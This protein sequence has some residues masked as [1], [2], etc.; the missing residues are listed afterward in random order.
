[1][2]HLAINTLGLKIDELLTRHLQLIAENRSL[3]DE[4]EKLRS[5]KALLSSKNQLAANKIKHVISQ[6][7]EEMHGRLA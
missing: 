2:S 3:R 7:R 5:E 4:I 6:L 1:M